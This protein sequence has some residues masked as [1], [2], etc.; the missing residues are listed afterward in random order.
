MSAPRFLL[1]EHIP[2]AVLRGLRRIAP[3]IQV[4]RVGEAEAPPL[5]TSDPDLL[6]W[7][8]ANSCFLVTNN[9]ASMPAHLRDHL[10]AGQHIPGI[11]I[12]PRRLALGSVIDQLH[13]IWL[14]SLPS[15]YQDRIVYLPI[16]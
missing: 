10:T 6:A 9:R 1:D 5:H 8:E 7:I 16:S 12:V 13:L 15:E 14:A 11:F 4:F 3:E 2:Y